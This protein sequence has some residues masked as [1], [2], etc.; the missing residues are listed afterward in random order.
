QR[1]EAQRP[2][3]CTFHSLGVQMLRRDGAALGLKRNFSIV[4]ADDAGSIV[5]QALGSVDRKTTRAAQHRIP[6]WK[7][8]LVDPD[9]AA[10][11]AANANEHAIARAYRDYAATLV[12]YQAVDFDDLIRLPVRLLR[13]NAD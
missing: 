1:H 11:S 13:E 2:L 4:D 6:L 3:V 12:A 8:A 9:E 7:N 5:Q 10:A